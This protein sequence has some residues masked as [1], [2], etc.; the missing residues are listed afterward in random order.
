MAPARARRSRAT[1]TG[2]TEEGM[3]EDNDGVP[4]L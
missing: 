3:D 1:V 2:K 4:A